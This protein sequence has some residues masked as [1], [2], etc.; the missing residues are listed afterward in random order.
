[1]ESPEAILLDQIMV[2]IQAKAPSVRFIAPDSGQLEFFELKP[3]VSW[4]CVLIDL[5]DFNFSDNG[6]D[7]S[8][9]GTGIIRLRI[10]LIQYTKV[11]N[12]TE[13]QYRDKGNS[14]FEVENEVFKALHGW[15]PNNSTVKLVRRRSGK[16]KREDDLRVRVIDFE[17]SYK[18]ITA[19]PAK[20]TIPRPGITIGKISEG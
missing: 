20:T 2:R 1:M 15:S 9:I 17:T 11:N 18:D 19:I 4:P 6:N 14:Y 8:Q 3:P 16:E 13:K 5:E 7:L 10:G 12:L